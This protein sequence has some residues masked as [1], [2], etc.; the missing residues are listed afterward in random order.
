MT[1]TTENDRIFCRQ[2]GRVVAEVTFPQIRPGQWSSTT[3]GWTPAC[4]ARALRAS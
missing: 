1:F 4:G 2:E 3:P